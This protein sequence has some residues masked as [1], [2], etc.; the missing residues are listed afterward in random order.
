M[1][2]SRCFRL[3][4]KVVRVIFKTFLWAAAIF[5]VLVFAAC[6]LFIRLTPSRHADP[7]TARV[8]REAAQEG[9]LAYRLTE[10]NELIRLLGRPAAQMRSDREG[11]QRLRLEW[12]G[13]GATFVA[14]RDC[15]TPT[16]RWLK[17][18]STCL[19]WPTTTHWTP[20]SRA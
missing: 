12:P 4:R 3:L 7:E 14:L 10:P 20:G 5:G 8:I 9:K 2:L 11:A 13:V 16:L 18:V 17:L 19:A 6:V 15:P 1:V